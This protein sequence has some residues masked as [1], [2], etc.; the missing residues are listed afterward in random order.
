M[1]QQPA[2]GN[3]QRFCK[4]CTTRTVFLSYCW[5]KISLY[6]G[7]AEA[8]SQ[9]S[10]TWVSLE[11]RSWR[12]DSTNNTVNTFIILDLGQHC[13]LHL[14][15][16]ARGHWDS[17]SRQWQLPRSPSQTQ[18]WIYAGSDEAMLKEFESRLKIFAG[19]QPCTLN[20]CPSPVGN[21]KTQTL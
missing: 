3:L 15:L 21:S 14:H 6:K 20:Q 2:L 18:E 8:D 16:L 5:W 9:R 17:S 7:G 10:L 11:G 12:D 1:G 19:L 13:D 4:Y